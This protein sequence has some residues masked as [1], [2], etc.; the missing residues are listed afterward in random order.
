MEKDVSMEEGTLSLKRLGVIEDRLTGVEDQLGQLL[1]EGQETK[2]EMKE[3]LSQI[4]IEI[5]KNT[6]QVRNMRRKMHASNSN[7]KWLFLSIIMILVVWTV[8]MNWFKVEAL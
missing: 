8:V 4:Q 3:K 7:S 5:E 6:S 1:A 2:I